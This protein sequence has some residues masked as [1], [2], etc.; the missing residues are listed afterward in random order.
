M[1]LF[2]NEHDRPQ[3]IKEKL[4]TLMRKPMPKNQEPNPA[5]RTID[6]PTANPFENPSP[7]PIE[8]FG[9]L[10][11]GARED[12]SG[13]GTRAGEHAVVP[14]RQSPSPSIPRPAMRQA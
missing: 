14:Y 7:R 13:P 9:D 5:P 11:R 4:Q 3:R 6:A 1:R 10:K 12:W 8:E 2:G